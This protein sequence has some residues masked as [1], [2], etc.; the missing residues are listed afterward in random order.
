MISTDTL[1]AQT[2]SLILAAVKMLEGDSEV[3]I[4][5]TLLK[6]RDSV[7]K[8]DP[9]K[10]KSDELLYVQTVLI[11]EV[12][13]YFYERLSSIPTILQYMQTVSGN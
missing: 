8:H 13:R 6:L 10:V 12:N 2:D 9:S 5:G 1:L 3:I 7:A 4:V 11:N